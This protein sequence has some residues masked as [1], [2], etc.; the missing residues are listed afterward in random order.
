MGLLAG[1]VVMIT[2]GARGQG[3]AH[4]VVSA[5]EG[6]SVVLVDIVDPIE[7]MF[8][9]TATEQD[10][11]E[12]V[13]QVEALGG[14][15]L[16]VS[17]DVR[18]Q[19]DLNGAVDAGIERFGQIDGLIANAGIWTMAPFWTMT[20]ERWQQTLDINLSGVWRAAKAVT[21][22]MIERRSGSIVMISSTCGMEPASTMAHYTAAKHGVIGLAKNVAVELAEYGIRCNCVCPGATDSGMTRNQAAWDFYAGGSGG[23]VA[24]MATAGT[25]YHALD[26]VAFLA[27]EEIAK[28]VLYLNSELAAT[29]T[30]VAIPVDAGHL[31]LTGQSHRAVR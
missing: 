12:T 7:D 30:G 20:E 29:V 17:G 22:H 9:P 14:S 1:K 10:M 28:T 8:Y 13:R 5:R 15:A 21:P 24:H 2:G 26:G 11:A 16:A 3:R 19:A 4:A 18:S 6:A 31:L 25:D 23:T 27:P